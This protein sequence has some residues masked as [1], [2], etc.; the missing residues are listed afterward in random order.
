MNLRDVAR[1]VGN[2]INP[3]SYVVPVAMGA[4]GA[5]QAPT[6]TSVNAETS[7]TELLDENTNRLGATVYND[8]SADLYL[9]LGSAASTT[10][11]TV[12]MVAQSYYE[13]PFGYTGAI[14]G[15]WSAATGAARIME[16][17]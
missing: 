6:A 2:P 14:Y 4:Y 1:P 3:D 12:K 9:K 5:S 13:V 15:I 8:S 7:S 17:E 11:F 16:L 10:S